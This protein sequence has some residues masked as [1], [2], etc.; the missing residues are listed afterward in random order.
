MNGLENNTV[1]LSLGSNIGDRFDYLRQAVKLL[2]DHSEICVEAVSSWYETEPVGYTDQPGFINIAVK[3]TTTLEP[4]PL[5]DICQAVEKELNRIRLIHWGPRTIDIDIL[6]YNEQ[7]IISDRLIIP[8]ERMY[9]RSF[10]LIPLMEIHPEAHI[11]KDLVDEEQ[12]VVRLE[13]KRSH[14]IPV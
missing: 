10:V 13:I 6:L 9:E 4:H 2:D 3:I 12:K 7:K 1:F 5:L 8:H 14:F 11:Y